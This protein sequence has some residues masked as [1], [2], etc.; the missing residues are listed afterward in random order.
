M[1]LY[2]NIF[3]KDSD[4]DGGALSKLDD[5]DKD[6]KDENNRN[7]GEGHDC[8]DREASGGGVKHRKEDPPVILGNVHYKAVYDWNEINEKIASGIDK[9]VAMG[10]IGN[11]HVDEDVPVHSTKCAY[12]RANEESDDYNYDEIDNEHGEGDGNTYSCNGDSN[13]CGEGGAT[14]NAVSSNSDATSIG[15]G[16]GGP[17]NVPQEETPEE[18]PNQGIEIQNNS[19]PLDMNVNSQ[20]PNVVVLAVNNTDE[21]DNAVFNQMCTIVAQ[22]RCLQ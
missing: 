20:V 4:D 15:S 1:L 10:S 16:D 21:E 6:D 12:D 2:N 9:Y 13:D 5:D 22:K 18:A 11:M 8:S 19:P 17:S 14:G 3:L 7:G